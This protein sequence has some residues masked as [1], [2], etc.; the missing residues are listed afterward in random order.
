MRSFVRFLIRTSAFLR[1]EI[2][3]ILRQPRLIVSLVLGPF[4]ILLLFGIGYRNQPPV[5]D[6]LFVVQPGSALEREIEQHATT[7]GPQL[8]YLGSTTDLDTA[9]EALRG[10]EVDLVAVAPTDAYE[11]ILNEEQA[12][13]QLY[14]NEIDPFQTDYVRYFGRIYIDEVNRRVL[15]AITDIGQER[16][17]TVREALAEARQN[18]AALREALE[19][20]D[21]AAARLHQQE[22]SRNLGQIETTTNT[23]LDLAE[24]VQ[25]TLGS[26]EASDT[27]L[28][29]TSISELR[30]DTTT[31]G[32][33]DEEQTD[34]GP[35]IER[36]T[37]IEQDLAALDEQLADFQR[38]NSRVL[39]SPFRTETQ[40][41]AAIQPQLAHY[42]APAVIVLLLQHLAVT[43]GAL[44]IV[45]E[46]QIGTVELFRVSP[47]TAVETL[48][49]KYLSYLLF[50]GVLVVI[51][52]LVLAASLVLPIPG[53]QPLL[54]N[55]EVTVGLGVPMLGS[56][57]SYALVTLA[58]L[59]TS[60][61]YGFVISLIV[62]TD[63]QAVQYAMILLLTSVFFSGFFLRLET[64]WE[65]VRVVS[66]MLPATYA[67]QMLQNIMLRGNP[68][69][70]FLLG[71]LF[72]VGAA[73]FA[74]A[75]F[76]L[77]RQMRQH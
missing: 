8:N 27:R 73:L 63:S 45:R 43:F 10:G 12:V 15:Q 71:T 46:A 59:F 58:L 44:S 37:E 3:E 1:K 61:G 77:H 6:T 26:G 57:T 32:Q 13:F 24:G 64:L 21:V 70:S 75:W 74:L 16:T 7:L 29:R 20:G 19:R 40:S 25:E 76:L 55:Q 23:T 17:I 68:P 14:H 42:F 62:D 33:L 35:Q 28:V 72:A 38:I 54:G 2:Y 65:P 41:I 51:L 30:E 60:L 66:W 50:G 4:L 22:L 34:L 5:L 11:T 53:L 49:G 56:W 67:I 36:A 48:L 9:L 39:V 31:I 52:T 18:A 47:I 69:S